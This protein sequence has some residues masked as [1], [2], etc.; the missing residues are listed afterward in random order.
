MSKSRTGRIRGQEEDAAKVANLRHVSDDRPGITR[1]RS[2]RGFS[3]L[4]MDGSV[5]RDKANLQRIRALAI[6]PAWAKVWICPIPNGHMQA[7]G[8][9]ARGRKQYRYHT[10]WNEVR[11]ATKYDRM[12]EFG[13]ALPAIRARL[14]EDLA[15]QAIPKEK[16]LATIISL[17]EATVIRVG[18]EEYARENHSYGLTTM[19]NRHIEIDGSQMRFRFRGKSGKV[20]DISVSDR[21]LARMV[22]RCRDLPGQDLFQYLDD[23]GEPQPIDSADVNEYLRCIAEHDFTAK[24]YR[25]WAGTL[26]AAEQ[27]VPLHPEDPAVPS[28]EA[29]ATAIAAV[30]DHLG[31][32]PAVCRKCYIHP[33]IL[34]AYQDAAEYDRWVAVSERGDCPERLSASEAALLRF[35]RA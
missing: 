8:R 7:T 32:T 15:R 13:S 24:D 20:H 3:Y 33:A 28:K 18:N 17:L 14:D 34:N 31:N 12:M 2:G 1:R 6:P 4:A 26:L 29:L 5:V 19:Q 11:D 25:T 22:Q 23:T 27:L 30:A 16:V 21:R 9:D 35:L 10:R